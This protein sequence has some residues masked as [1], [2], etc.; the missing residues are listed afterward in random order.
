[1]KVW[2]NVHRLLWLTLTLAAAALAG[3]AERLPLKTYT[4]ADGLAHNEINRIVRDSRGFLWFCTAEGL[5]RFDGYTFTNY[6]VDDGLPHG[7]VTDFLETRDGELWLATGAGLVRFNPKGTPSDSIVYANET[8]GGDPPMFT[9]VVPEDEDRRASYITVLLE[10][11]DGTIWAGTRK[12][13]YR[14]ERSAGRLG[15]RYVEM[16]RPDG[17]RPAIWDLLEDRYGSLWVAYLGALARRWPDGSTVHYSRRDGLPDDNIHDLFEDGR[18]QLWAGTRLGGFFLFESDATHAPPVVKRAY[19]RRDGLITDWVSQLFETSDGRFW[20]ATGSGIAEFFPEADGRE[21]RF[22]NYTQSN[23]LLYFGINSLSEDA[24]GNLWL[25]SDAGAMKLA[26]EGFTSY[27]ERDGLLGVF[28]IFGDRTGGVCFR[29]AVF[30][31]ERRTVFEGAKPEL[32]RPLEHWHSRFGRFDGEGFTWLLPNAIGDTRIGWVGEMLTLQAR[33]GEWWVGTGEGI[34]R[35]PATDDFGLLKR[36]RPLAVY[37]TRDGLTAPQVFRLFEDSRGDVWVSAIQPHGLAR[38]ERAGETWRD[39]TNAPGLPPPKDDLA[40]S[41]GEDRDGN[42]WVGFSSGAARYRDGRFAFFDAD[43]GLPPGAVQNIYS[44]GAG[45]LWL[46]SA[47]SGLVRVDAP[48]TER[49]AFHAYTTEQGLSSNTA[50]GITEDLRGHIYVGTGRGLDRLDP[51]TG[52]VKHFTTADGLAPGEVKAA[53][54]A[55]DGALWIGTV[56]GLSRFVP[57]AGAPTSAPPP[58]LLTALSVAGERQTVS[59]QGETALTLPRLAPDRNQ[60]QIDFVGLSFAPGEVLRYQ[61]RL[62]GTG[63]DWGPPTEQ[64]RVNFASLAPGSYRFAVLAVNSDG[65]TSETPAT[66]TFTVLRPVWQRWW[67]ITLATLAVGLT[68]FAAYRYRVRRLLEVADMRTRIA[69][70]LHDDI[71]A[72]LTKIA[73]L[74]EVAKQQIGANGEGDEG[75]AERDSVETA[76]G[77]VSGGGRTGDTLSAIASISRES[78]ASMG[79]I[80]W[81]INPQRDSL[82]DM[83]RRMRRHAEEVCLARDIALTFAAPDGDQDLRLGVDVRRDLYLVFKEA[84]GNAARHSGCSR[85]EV[86]LSLG[87]EGLALVIADNG[88]GFDPAADTDGNG[89][90]NMRARARKLGAKIEIDSRPG[91]GTR[92]SLR[93]PLAK[94]ARARPPTRTGR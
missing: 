67:F 84:T 31:D 5:S 20:V 85:L 59:A 92:I 41:F 17:E 7:T 76:G 42:V 82:R 3:R 46:A 12:G 34:Y 55:S 81:A 83:I 43:D 71:G 54:R 52:H 11:R 91:R 47:H 29:G 63:A 23:G 74:S 78:V 64:R 39:L 45:R 21:P 75:V 26:R 62:E 33:N 16:P 4:T 69:T 80:V 89:L 30:G 51:A 53:F 73:I 72:N 58:I 38:W 77:G 27:G 1:M 61:Y 70:D 68:A 35:F 48:G 24:G 10:G 40:R 9:A 14:L 32:L 13:V 93:L 28:A 49:P 56:K 6:G 79:D 50:Q 18:R 37:T 66:V 19:S 88:S 60:L 8:R 86:A 65:V 87:R 25:S 36:V 57:G 2:R 94:R 15:L 90:L 44:D 22:R